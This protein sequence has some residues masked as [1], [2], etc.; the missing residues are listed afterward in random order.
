[1]H[2]AVG[3]SRRRAGRPSAMGSM[4]FRRKAK[5]LSVPRL[6][7]TLSAAA[8]ATARRFRRDQSGVT[9]IEFGAVAAPFFA[10]LF[11]II[12]TALTLWTTQVLETGV[13]NASRRIYTGQFQQDNAATDPT[14]IAGK[15]RDEI[16]KSIVA[17]IT[18][19]KIQIDVRTLASFPGQKPQ[20]PI[21]ADGQ[22][23]SA[24]FGKYEPPGANQIVVVR[25][26][27]EYPVFVSL[28]NPNQSNLQNGNR[29]IMG[30]AAFRTEPF[31]Q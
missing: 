8:R 25:A 18:C 4:M 15:F 12:E 22:F 28:L 27:V 23:D 5:I 13:G 17:L 9:A 1:M 24:N 6:A 20:K 19:D 16:C 11:A 7:R 2:K 3:G 31:A 14:L 30:T 26:A 29:L 21:T 10:L